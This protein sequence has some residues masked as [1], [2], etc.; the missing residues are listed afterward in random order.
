MTTIVKIAA[1]CS[2]DKQVRVQIASDGCAAEE[3]VLQNG[4]IAE[5][6]AHDDRRI[7]VFEELKQDR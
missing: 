4:E 6:Y 2:D 5:R 7:T 3:F 1:H